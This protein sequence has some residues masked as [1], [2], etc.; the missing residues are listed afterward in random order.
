[1][2]QAS[3]AFFRCPLWLLVYRFSA[4]NSRIGLPFLSRISLGSH[5]LVNIVPSSAS[6]KV[7]AQYYD[8]LPSSTTVLSR[9]L[10]TLWRR[11][12]AIDEGVSRRPHQDNCR[13][14]IVPKRYLDRRQ[15]R[16]SAISGIPSGLYSQNAGVSQGSARS[17]P[18]AFG[19]QGLRRN[20]FR[21]C[22]GTFGGV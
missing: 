1:M 6:N 22:V 2:S 13:P 12:F 4:L 15:R 5:L 18:L 11:R 20:G 19:D 16:R 10:R 14:S 9:P 21:R 8:L 3:P 17:L 7:K